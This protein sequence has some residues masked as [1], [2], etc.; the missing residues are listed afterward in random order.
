[1][2]KQTIAEQKQTIAEQKQSWPYRINPKRTRHCWRYKNNE[3]LEAIRRRLEGK[4]YSVKH[5]RE[6][7]TTTREIYKPKKDQ[8]G[9]EGIFEEERI[10]E[11]RFNTKNMRVKLTPSNVEM[12]LPKKVAELTGEE[13]RLY[14]TFLEQYPHDHSLGY[15][16]VGVTLIGF[17]SVGIPLLSILY[18]S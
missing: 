10:A 7:F 6:K 5:I 16:L 1:M 18:Q 2:A 9:L 17:I 13:K 15:T 4:R 8:V 11:L 14:N 12:E 3:E